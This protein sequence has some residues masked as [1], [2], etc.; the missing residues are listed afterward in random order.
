[1]SIRDVKT[2]IR[3]PTSEI[4]RCKKIKCSVSGCDKS[5][6]PYKG[7]GEKDLCSDH[8][9]NRMEFGGMAKG[10]VAHSHH[11]KRVCEMCGFDPALD[12]RISIFQVSDPVMFNRLCRSVL[13]VDHMDGKHSN[14][15]FGNH[16]TGCVMC[17]RIKTT[18]SGDYLSSSS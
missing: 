1:M 17:H 10:G 8:Q 5:L 13:E 16:K 12:P 9:K 11:R 6:T 2:R 18:I 4:M 3:K 15:E 14:D 7:P